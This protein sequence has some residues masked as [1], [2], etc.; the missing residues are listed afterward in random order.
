M[1]IDQTP[2]DALYEYNH[3]YRLVYDAHP[4]TRYVGNH[5]Y[6][7]NGEMVHRRTLYDEIDRLRDLARKKRARSSSKG[8]IRRLI[9]KI[10][11]L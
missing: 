3:A 8:M 4:R 9:D 5:W 10:R 2:E 1:T 6:Q 11:L 7:I